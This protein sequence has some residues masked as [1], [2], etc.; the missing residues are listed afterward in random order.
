MSAAHYS[1]C[2]A[3]KLQRLNKSWEMSVK[4]W[5]EGALRDVEL[6][7]LGWQIS[8]RPFL[9]DKVS[10]LCKGGFGLNRMKSDC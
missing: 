1:Q 4:K 5:R 7:V 8:E 2:S 10:V 9:I 6:L 3:R